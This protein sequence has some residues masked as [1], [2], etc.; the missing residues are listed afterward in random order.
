MFLHFPILNSLKDN[1]EAGG[2]HYQLKRCI[3]KEIFYEKNGRGAIEI[4]NHGVI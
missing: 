4:N 2:K 1:I 3:P